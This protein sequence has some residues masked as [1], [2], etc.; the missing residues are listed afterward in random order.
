VGTLCDLFISAFN[1]LIGFS[2][3]N[4]GGDIGTAKYPIT[5]QNGQTAF[6]TEPIG[7]FAS[8]QSVSQFLA[9]YDACK[10]GGSSCPECGCPPGSLLCDQK[11]V[12]QGPNACG[13]CN[14]PCAPGETCQIS[15]SGSG[16]CVCPAS[17]QCGGV[18][19]PSGQTC[20]NGACGFC[21]VGTT[22]NPS[23][24]ECDC[25][26][27]NQV[28]ND[29]NQ[30]ADKC[31]DVV[32]PSGQTCNNGACGFCGAGTTV[33]SSSGECQCTDPTQGLVD[34]N[35][36]KECK[37]CNS[38]E[39]LKDGACVA[40]PS[41]TPT[42]CKNFN[43]C[44]NLA[45]ILSCGQDCNSLKQCVIPTGGTASCDNGQCKQAC[46]AG[47]VVQ[48][49]ACAPCPAGQVPNAAGDA[50]QSCP[51]GQTA[52]NGQCVDLSSP[53]SCGTS[54]APGQCTIQ[55]CQNPS[56]GTAV[57]TNGQCSTTTCTITSPGTPS[58]NGIVCNGAC[59]NPGVDANCGRCDRQCDEPISRC[60]TA[61][62]DPTGFACIPLAPP[63][64]LGQGKCPTG[65]T[66]PDGSPR[67]E[68]H[69]LPCPVV[70]SP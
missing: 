35:G 54:T 59:V 47:E 12:A 57:C 45:S 62:E 46:I 5:C 40:C 41:E 55:Q 20:N 58:F 43:E 32:C 10:S 50:C 17:Q 61:P 30:C 1:A 52:C 16:A 13:D 48:N 44:V 53:Q 56:G 70:P 26:N 42:A 8:E 69:I 27:P 33:D 65:A 15:S 64:P 19:C 22:M 68:C 31:G 36:H 6:I 9:H 14:H 3:N 29:Q 18:C 25:P 66:N 4:Q 39:I 51:S 21:P 38:N 2:P 24:G 49:G 34:V 11:C 63:C 28:L 23:T 37:A 67:L 7:D 60:G